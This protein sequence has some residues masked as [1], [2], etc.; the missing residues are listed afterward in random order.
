MCQSWPK[1]FAKHVMFGRTGGPPFCNLQGIPD[2]CSPKPGLAFIL[3]LVAMPTKYPGM[4]QPDAICE[5]TMQQNATV[6]GTTPQTR[7]CR[8]SLQRSLDPLACSGGEGRW[9]R[10]AGL[11]PM[12]SWINRLAAADWLRRV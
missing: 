10:A 4:L 5:H 9:K 7:S 8:G 12:R 11:R 6:A 2:S 1:E 3:P